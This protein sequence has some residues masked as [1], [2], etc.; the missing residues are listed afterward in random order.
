MHAWRRCSFG[1]RWGFSVRVG[2]N[3][4]PTLQSW[5]IRFVM[6]RIARSEGASTDTS[7]DYEYTDWSAVARFGDA[8]VK[9]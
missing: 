9:G 6:K 5:L 1:M 2:T 3:P 8:L 4:V 7:R